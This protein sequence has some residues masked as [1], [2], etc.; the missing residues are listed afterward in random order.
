MSHFT[1]QSNWPPAGDPST[2]PADVMGAGREST[3]MYIS[4]YVSL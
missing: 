1:L 4:F 2:N 3:K